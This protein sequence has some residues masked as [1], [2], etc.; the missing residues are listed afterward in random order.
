[1]ALS[2]SGVS[3]GTAVSFSASAMLI[4]R[5]PALTSAATRGPKP[6]DGMP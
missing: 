1:M 4:T 5:R 3:T 6:M 2:R